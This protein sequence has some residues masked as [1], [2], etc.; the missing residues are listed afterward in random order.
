[1]HED[2]LE[3]SAN[4]FSFRQLRSWAFRERRLKGGGGAENGTDVPS[5]LRCVCI[6]SRNAS[7]I[8]FFGRI[9][10]AS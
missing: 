6:V 2:K 1:M 7:M 9:A 3:P 4:I 10:T 5:R 8:D